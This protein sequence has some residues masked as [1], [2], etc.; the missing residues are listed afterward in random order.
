MIS[1]FRVPLNINNPVFGK[2]ASV[3]AIQQGTNYI[4][5][6]LERQMQWKNYLTVNQKPVA[7]F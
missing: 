5:T 4:I 2:Q 7:A 6:F 3:L 1:K